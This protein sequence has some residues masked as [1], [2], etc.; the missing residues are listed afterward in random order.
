MMIL[1]PPSLAQQS[2][3]NFFFF[4]LQDWHYIQQWIEMALGL[5]P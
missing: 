4:T 2:P 5:Q 1:S 3:S